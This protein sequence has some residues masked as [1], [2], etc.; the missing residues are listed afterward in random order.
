MNSSPGLVRT[1]STK[2]SV[3]VMRSCAPKLKFD[4]ASSATFAQ[5]VQITSS[6]LVLLPRRARINVGVA[7]F[8][9]QKYVA[10]IAEL[11]VFTAGCSHYA[12]PR[13][14]ISRT[15]AVLHAE[16][17]EPGAAVWHLRA[18]LNV[19]ALAC[20]GHG[21]VMVRGAYKRLLSRHR[22]LLADAYNAEQRR[23]G[24][25]FDRSQTRLYNRFSN[26]HDPVQFCR[27]SANVSHRAAATD[28]ATL[29]ENAPRLLREL[30]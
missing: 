2:K 6:S 9:M 4:S 17:A 3:K 21:R 8:I 23:Q 29:A 22:T 14:V 13:L 7:G 16:V 30:R 19:A 20:K 18:G 5:A 24:T 11:V 15:P 12:Q 27:E 10:V 1:P 25:H 28:T 26:Q